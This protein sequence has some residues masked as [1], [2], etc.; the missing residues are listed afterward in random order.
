VDTNKLIS[1]SLVSAHLEELNKLTKGHSVGNDKVRKLLKDSLVFTDVADG[2]SVVCFDPADFSQRT[3]LSRKAIQDLFGGKR[4]FDMLLASTGSTA[5]WAYDPYGPMI[6]FDRA[7]VKLN[8]YVPPAWKRTK[9]FYPSIVEPVVD[10]MPAAYATFFEHLTGGDAASF[11]YL[12]DW[13]ASSLRTRNYTILVAIGAPG[14]GKTTLAEIICELHGQTNSYQ[15]RD[16]V[17]KNRFNYQL[18]NKTFFYID[19]VKLDSKEAHDRIKA[20]VNDFMEIERKGKDPVLT[21]NYASFYLSSNDYDAIKIEAGDR[22]FS[23]IQLT[24]TKLVDAGLTKIIDELKSPEKIAQL[25]RYLYARE[26]AQEKMLRPFVNSVRFQDVRDAAL[27]EWERYLCHEWARDNAGKAD[28]S[29]RDLQEHLMTVQRLR[30]RSAPGRRRFEQ[31]CQKMPE[32][33]E[34]RK[35]AQNNW[36][37]RSKV[38]LDAVAQ[39]RQDRVLKLRGPVVTSEEEGKGDGT[40]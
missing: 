18:A 40:I 29:Y 7:L 21:K 35:G 31:L 16:E 25:G 13:L 24:D 15:G 38:E 11:E 2:D 6:D 39:A 8:T 23:V 3:E 5:T 17:F 32:F 1:A 34:L 26:V 30:L 12:L 27:S 22:R 19:E 37:I 20:V 4:S 10:K 14:I 33:L 9:F 36:K 28:T